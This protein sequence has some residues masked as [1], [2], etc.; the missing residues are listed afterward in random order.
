MARRRTVEEITA[1]LDAKSA[2]LK[3]DAD[4]R[5]AVSADGLCN[6]LWEAECALHRV[7]LCT[8]DDVLK[9]LAESFAGE[10]KAAREARWA[11][12]RKELDTP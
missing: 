8:T 11:T 5:R 4:R 12:L 7:R 1:E 3:S 2:R 9:G 10:M 6:Y